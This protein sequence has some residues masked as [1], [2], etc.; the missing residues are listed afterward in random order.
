MAAQ[1]ERHSS[2][3]EDRTTPRAR[4]RRILRAF[5]PA[6]RC[7]IC[8]RKNRS[9]RRLVVGRNKVCVC[10]DCVLSASPEDVV[11]GQS[12]LPRMRH[13]VLC[14]H[15]VVSAWRIPNTRKLLCEACRYRVREMIT[16]R[17]PSSAK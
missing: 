9:P 13:C 12:R 11:E 17:P 10:T 5:R 4:L 3:R 7:S 1:Q 15:R 8:H 6:L 16:E 2:R 14:S